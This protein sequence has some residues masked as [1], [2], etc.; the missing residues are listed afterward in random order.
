[1]CILYSSQQ[2]MWVDI[3]LCILILLWLCLYKDRPAK[4]HSLEVNITHCRH[5]Y[6]TE[7]CT[8]CS[9]TCYELMKGGGGE[10]FLTS[11]SFQSMLT[12]VFVE[13]LQLAMT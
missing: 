3:K 13:L 2:E 7:I 10:F 4:S 6:F 12:K 5:T 11:Y 9:H 1:M 8:D